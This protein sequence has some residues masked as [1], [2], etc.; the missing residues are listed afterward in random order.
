MKSLDFRGTG[1]LIR[2]YF[3]QN[4]ITRAIWLFTPALLAMSA[5]ASYGSMF[6]SQQ[7][8]NAFVDEN[9]LNPVV[10]AIHGF[11]LNNDIPSIVSWNI[12]T[13]SLIVIAIFNILAVSKI[14]R[15]EEETGRADLLQSGMV[16]RQSLFAASI[17]ISYGT[18]IVMGII[19]FITMLA[20]G[21]PVGGSLTLS[22]LLVVG[23]C[24]FASI[25]AFT[26]QLASARRTA[27]SL[28][29]GVMGLFYMMSFMNNLSADN[30]LS[31]YFT[32][33]RWFF[34]VRPFAGNHL[35]FLLVAAVLVAA[36]AGIGLFLSIKRDVGA[37]IIHPKTGRSAATPGFSNVFALGWRMHRGMLIAW[38]LV[39]A[40]FSL[41]IGSVD[42]LVTSMLN[43]QPTLASWMRLF[44]EPEEAFLSLMVYVL[45]LF[46]SAYG[47]LA[48]HKMRSE[49]T[50]GRIETLLSTPVERVKWMTS[51]ATFSVVG[52]AFIMLIIGLCIALGSVASGGNADAFGK[53]M[54]MS[55]AK[56]PAVLIMA[57][58][59]A[60]AFGFLPKISVGIS[61]TIYSLFILIQLLWEMRLVPDILFLA[62][63]FGQVYPTQPQTLVVFM[64]LMIVAAILYGMSLLF[65]KRRDIQG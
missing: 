30:N 60:L 38:T 56:L 46:V 53:I 58:I 39:L 5:M 63:P 37:G 44:G 36:I 45:C 24:L 2:F 26:S 42:P 54:L 32:P 34:I 10:A 19:L 33:F 8:L 14:I 59:A 50:E 61:W 28:G 57:G 52:S 3:R 62:S 15:G 9:I 64:V 29:I 1:K 31:S 11:I 55:I 22:C 41:G 48:V 12:K 23:G 49:E 17:I 18:N 35:S 51:H 7:E 47:M 16:G 4:W 25:G 13:V 40:V 6:A 21:L 27:S 65:F 43:E 20:Y